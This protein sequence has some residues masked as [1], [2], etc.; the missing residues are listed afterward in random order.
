MYMCFVYERVKIITQSF[1]FHFSN[2]SVDLEN[3]NN[4]DEWYSYYFEV[5]IYSLNMCTYDIVQ[6]Y[7]FIFMHTHILFDIF[8]NYL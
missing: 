3:T 2:C 7:V 1:H 5:S 8:M 6:L 4:L